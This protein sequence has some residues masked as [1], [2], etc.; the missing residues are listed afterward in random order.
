M[1][2]IVTFEQALYFPSSPPFSLLKV[3]V[4]PVIYYYLGMMGSGLIY[5]F[6]VSAT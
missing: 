5:Y 3:K 4:G 1:I 6:T 2:G